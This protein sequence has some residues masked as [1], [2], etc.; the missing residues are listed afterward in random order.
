MKQTYPDCNIEL[1][2]ETEEVHENSK[3]ASPDSK[4]CLVWQFVEAVAL[5]FPSGSESVCLL[6]TVRKDVAFQ[7]LT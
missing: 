1:S 3:V 2:D 4:G 5:S 7:G 6:A